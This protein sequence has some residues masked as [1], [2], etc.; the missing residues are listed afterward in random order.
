M[1][2]A[3][4]EYQSVYSHISSL[5]REIQNIASSTASN[6]GDP[7]APFVSPTL[8]KTLSTVLEKGIMECFSKLGAVGPLQQEVLSQRHRRAKKIKDKRSIDTIP[9]THLGPRVDGQRV[10]K[11]KRRRCVFWKYFQTPFG[12]VSLHCDKYA[13][14]AFENWTAKASCDEDCVFEFRITFVPR[15]WLFRRASFVTGTWDPFPGC[16]L[17]ALNLK[18]RP[19]VDSNSAIFKACKAGDVDTMK[20]LFQRK[21]ASPYDINLRGEDLLMVSTLEPAYIQ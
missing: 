21:Q 1:N 9:K 2:K 5:Q 12:H 10:S 18:F 13:H 14:D 19:V 8:E 11:V 20:Y 15:P 6:V 3:T 16:S 7:L 4:A 17:T